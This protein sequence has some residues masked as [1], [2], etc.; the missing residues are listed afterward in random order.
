[1]ITHFIMHYLFC[2]SDIA[3][4]CKH[5]LFFVHQIGNHVPEK[6]LSQRNDSP[7]G[8]VSCTPKKCNS[9]HDSECHF[10]VFNHLLDKKQKW[11]DKFEQ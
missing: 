10:V 5:L 7:Y 1:M 11:S 8:L 4:P 9:K 2:P 6:E 3:F